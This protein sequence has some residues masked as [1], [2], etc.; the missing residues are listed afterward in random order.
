MEDAGGEIL[1]A[2]KNTY[3]ISDPDDLEELHALLCV[4]SKF[5]HSIKLNIEQL[6]LYHL[7]IIYD[8]LTKS[9]K[10]VDSS[11]TFF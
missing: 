11:I 6:I 3:N 5:R 4:S 9:R 10:K 1:D 8:S 7:C 2:N